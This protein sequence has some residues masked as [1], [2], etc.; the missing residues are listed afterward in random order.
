MG[1]LSIFGVIAGIV[2]ANDETAR[3]ALTVVDEEIGDGGAVWHNAS[4]IIWCVDGVFTCRIGT[5][6]IGRIAWDGAM[7]SEPSVDEAG[8]LSSSAID[9]EKAV[10]TMIWKHYEQM[11]RRGIEISLAE[12]I[13][14]QNADIQYM[15]I[16]VTKANIIER[17]ARLFGGSM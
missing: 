9:Q 5:Y 11:N 1:V 7:A 4:T 10:Y 14:F 16:K 15:K 8:R 13:Y 2:K 17:S 3:N 12:Q 6:I